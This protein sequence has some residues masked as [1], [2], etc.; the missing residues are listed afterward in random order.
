MTPSPSVGV[1]QRGERADRAAVADARASRAGTWTA[2]SSCRGRSSTSASI[3]VLA[4]STIVTPARWWARV[5]ALL[6][7]P[8]DVRE[9]DAVVDAEREVGVGER[10]RLRPSWPGG[11]QQRQHVGQVE[12]ALGVVGVELGERVEQRAAVEQVEAGVDLA[13]RELLGRRVARAPSSPRRA[14][15]RR[16]RRGRRGRSRSG[17]RAPSSRASPPA[18]ASSCAA[19]SPA[20]ASPV[21]SGMSPLMT[22]TGASGSIVAGGGRDGVAGAARLLL[23]RDLD[24]VGQVPGERAASGLSTTTTRSAPAARAASSGQRIIGRPQIGCRTLGSAE[25][26][27]VPSPAARMTTV[28]AGMVSHRSIAVRER[29]RWGVV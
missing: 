8:R 29:P 23:D 9:V 14:R 1:D 7:E 2:R 11:A 27:R 28:G 26:I 17:R 16:R 13:D 4:G 15:R 12:L 3:S 21:I 20:I 25:R 18:P 22:S 10:V 24:A 6:G 19:T 5:D